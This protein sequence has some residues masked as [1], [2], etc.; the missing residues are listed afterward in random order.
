MIV[1]KAMFDLYL[2]RQGK[3]C[4]AVKAGKITI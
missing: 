3:T 4:E 2:Q 1:H